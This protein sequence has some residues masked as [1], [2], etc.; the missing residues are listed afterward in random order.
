MQ[1]GSF[2]AYR[3][4]AELPD[5]DQDVPDVKVLWNKSHVA[6]RPH[7]CDVCNEEIATGTLY[8][9]A[10]WI[11]DGTFETSK[12][13]GAGGYPSTC[14]RFAEQDRQ[15]PAEQFEA[16]RAEFFPAAPSAPQN[17]ESGS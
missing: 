15:Q 9:S 2:W 1:S 5:Y 8:R 16:D 6:Q 11:I 3:E 13:H 4:A 14:P 7:L 12:T 17:G 10:G